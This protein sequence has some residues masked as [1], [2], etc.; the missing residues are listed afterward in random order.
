M[1]SQLVRS[2]AVYSV[3]EQQPLCEGDHP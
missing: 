3:L 2:G 1:K